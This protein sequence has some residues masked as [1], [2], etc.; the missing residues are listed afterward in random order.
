MRGM[1]G[2]GQPAEA[3]ALRTAESRLRRI[4][5]FTPYLTLWD[6]PSDPHSAGEETEAE[7]GHGARTGGA[8]I[9]AR[10]SGLSR[11]SQVL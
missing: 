2:R 7:R 10:V 11:V 6:G 1:L 8:G 3:Q 5:S 4:S 9:G